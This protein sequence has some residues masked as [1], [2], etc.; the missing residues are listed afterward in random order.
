VPYN[1]CKDETNTRPGHTITTES[2]SPR[3]CNG[4]VVDSRA[5]RVFQASP[6]GFSPRCPAF[7]LSSLLIKRTY[8]EIHHS[9]GVGPGQLIARV[10]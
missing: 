9:R 5:Y 7:A 8:A 4:D 2:L 1:G 6:A 10:K 3:L